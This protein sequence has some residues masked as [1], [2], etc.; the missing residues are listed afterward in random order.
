MFKK[1]IL[2]CMGLFIYSLVISHVAAQ[3]LPSGM[4]FFVATE[5]CPSGSN[6]AKDAAG[7]VVMVNTD[8]S[9]VGKTYGTA[10]KDQQDNVHTHTGSM[11]VNLPEHSVAGAASCCN[12]QATTKGNHTASFT[13]GE[14]DT[15]LPF[16]Q[17]L[18]CTAE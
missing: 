13:T 4:V 16:I 8:T 2:V 9:Q 15:N 1:Q 11:T 6:A 5:S 7:R 18:A 14:S 3:D 10:M 17:L 12:G